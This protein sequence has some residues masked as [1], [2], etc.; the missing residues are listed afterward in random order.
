MDGGAAPHL[1]GWGGEGKAIM[2]AR[3]HFALALALGLALSACSSSPLRV[4]FAEGHVGL[5]PARMAA[6]GSCGDDGDIGRRS[7][8]LATPLTERWQ[9]AGC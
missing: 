8:I 7:A 2:Q 1:I 5:T 6:S 3:I 9:D 4:A